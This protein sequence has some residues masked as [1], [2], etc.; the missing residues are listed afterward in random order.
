MSRY[1]LS[2]VIPTKNRQFYCLKAVKQILD[3]GDKRI[4][5]IVQDNSSENSLW[6]SLAGLGADKLQQIKYHYSRGLLSFTDNF[7]EALIWADGKY[8]SVIGD[9]DGVMPYIAD[10]AEFMEAGG[11]E[12]LIPGLN[13]VYFWPSE[14]PVIPNGGKGALNLSYLKYESRCVDTGRGLSRL[15]QRGGQDYLSLDLP[16]LY[17]GI[18]S[19]AALETVK[20]KAGRHFGGLSPDIYISAALALCCRRVLRVRFPVT[21]SGICPTS[22]SADSASGKHTGRLEEAPHFKGHRSYNWSIRVPAFYSVET[23]WADTVLHALSD[24]GRQDIAEAFN[25]AALDLKCRL[26]HPQFSEII[27]GH[28]KAN[29][30]GVL[31]LARNYCRFHIGGFLRKSFR[32]ATRKKGAV[33]K[34]RGIGDIS[35]AVRLTME[36]IETEKI[37]ALF[38]A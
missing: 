33:V 28:R 19:R 7:N 17:H 30:V 24:M 37:Y 11:I 25:I 26:L 38:Q 34:L 12:A 15:M 32:R 16:R 23:I 8:L 27:K 5:I 18:V 22:G 6:E 20:E 21:I 13:T 14:H 2:V 29:G 3:I 1:L 35:E 9:D 36:R 4:Q 10:V 31:A